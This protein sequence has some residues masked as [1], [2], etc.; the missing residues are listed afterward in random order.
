MGYPVSTQILGSD[1]G[2]IRPIA[3]DSS[4]SLVISG[5]S[6][7]LAPLGFEIE[8]TLTS[9]MGAVFAD[10]DLLPTMKLSPDLSA[11]QLIQAD[12]DY[13]LTQVSVTTSTP[14]QTLELS[15]TAALGGAGTKTTL[16]TAA[17]VTIITMR[18]SGSTAQRTLAVASPGTAVTY[19]IQIAFSVAAV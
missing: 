9:A 6:G 10:V 13:R 15:R 17:G 11:A 16:S 12:S 14:G 2:I 1:G 8:T 3:T 5:A 7:G 19:Q 4:G 18:Y